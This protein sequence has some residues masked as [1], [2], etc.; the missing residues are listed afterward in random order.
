MTLQIPVPSI[1]TIKCTYGDSLKTL[2]SYIK[3]QKVQF[4]KNELQNRG[5]STVGNKPVLLQRLQTVLPTITIDID[6][7]E[8]MQRIVNSIMYH[9]G[10]DNTHLFEMKMPKRGDLKD[11]VAPLWLSLPSL[12]IGL[13][14]KQGGVSP[15]PR[16]RD[17]RINRRFVQLG[18]TDEMIV[19]IQ[20]HP[21]APCNVR[22]ITGSG[23][24]PM[25]KRRGEWCEGDAADGGWFSLQ[26]LALE[27]GDKVKLLYDFGQR[28]EFFI[29]IQD[30]KQNV[31]VLPEADL[32]GHKTRAKLVDKGASK[33]RKQYN[34]GGSDY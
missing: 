12:D 32:Y 18:L 24:D 23:F 4:I 31:P 9:F 27:K 33:M 10:W 6:S 22:R 34:H 21:D 5:L 8:S 15:D 7:R 14:L 16:R 3:S 28:D 2:T 19:Q 30:V 17:P 26:E 29:Q 13:A 25:M 1:Y 11:G 20:A